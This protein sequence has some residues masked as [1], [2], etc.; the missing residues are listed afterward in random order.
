VSGA[1]ITMATDVYYHQRRHS[2]RRE[3]CLSRLAR[4]E[5]PGAV[6]RCIIAHPESRFRTMC[7]SSSP[8]PTPSP[9]KAIGNCA[10]GRP[11]HWTCVP[12]PAPRRPWNFPLRSRLPHFESHKETGKWVACPT[13]FTSPRGYHY[14]AFGMPTPENRS[15]FEASSSRKYYLV[16]KAPRS[17]AASS[18]TT[19]SASVRSSAPRS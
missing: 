11:R 7:S 15:S 6:R 2:A 13:L 17:P 12:I 9:P 18:S 14:Q 5:H 19:G 10:E 1:A 16:V 8:T 3:A 4:Q